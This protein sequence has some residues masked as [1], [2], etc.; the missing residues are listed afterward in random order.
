MVLN[1]IPQRIPAGAARISAFDHVVIN[2]LIVM[3]SCFIMGLWS[4]FGT[5]HYRSS[6][7][8][9]R[10]LA[11]VLVS[12]GTGVLAVIADLMQGLVC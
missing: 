10:G 9:W 3:A 4:I 1:T 11:G 5:R 2:L 8:F 7:I 6:G 12:S